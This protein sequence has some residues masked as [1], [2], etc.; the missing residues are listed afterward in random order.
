MPTFP[1]LTSY[2]PPGASEGTLDP[3]GLYLIADQLAIQLVPAVRERMQRIR[4]LTAMAVG[5]IVTEGLEDDPRQ[6]DASPYLVWEWLVV[7]ALIRE[8]GNDPSIWG[9]PGTLVARRALSQHGYLDARSYLKTPRIFGFNGVYKR[10]AIHLRL[11]D[12]HLAPGPNAEILTDAWARGLGYAGIKDVNPLLSRWTTAVRRSLDEKP[13][14]TKPNWSKDS[15]TELATAFA[16]RNAMGREKRYL[17]DSLNARDGR[18][19]GA[20]PTLWQLQPE[21]QDDKFREEL[22]HDRL[23]K[24]EPN[25]KPRIEAIRAYEAFARGLQDGF[26]V[27]KA[28]AARMDTKGF[29]VSGI[30]IDSDFQRSTK[31]LHNRFEAVH[32]AFAELPSGNLSL[33]NLFGGRFAC[34]AEPMDAVTC[35]RALCTHHESVQKGK[36]ADGKRPWFDRV[37]KDRIYIRHA[38]RERRR[39]I[40]PDRYVH[41]YRGQPIRRFFFDLQ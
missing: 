29:D 40:Q 24:I 15:W 2:D 34:F 27:L 30:A 26:D 6:R 19:L 8:M 17:R 37:S 12:V 21:F 14:R 13:P 36:S 35:A 25:Y 31:D 1:F 39:D 10:L 22:L 18:R 11:V 33:Q 20:L 23:E 16:P 32:R 4:F 9:V 3:L 41:D 5:A 28:E 7:E 38:Y